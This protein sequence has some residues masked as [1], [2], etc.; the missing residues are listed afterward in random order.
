LVYCVLASTT[1]AA[2]AEAFASVSATPGCT[3][4]R[5]CYKRRR[6]AT[7]SFGRLSS[8]GFG[9]HATADATSTAD[10]TAV[11]EDIGVC[12]ATSPQPRPLRIP[13]WLSECQAGPAAPPSAKPCLDRLDPKRIA[14]AE[15]V[16]TPAAAPKDRAAASKGRAKAASSGPVE[17]MADG[18]SNQIPVA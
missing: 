13:S 6:T 9:A 18:N 1:S 2:T 15:R 4:A 11:T 14:A 8:R 10:A 17:H 3:L 12:R 16:A 7:L 5:S